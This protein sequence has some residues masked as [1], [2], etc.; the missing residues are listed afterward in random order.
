MSARS[1]NIF[2]DLE[3][4][5]SIGGIIIVF[6]LLRLL[7]L[8][9]IILMIQYISYKAKNNVYSMAA[10]GVLFVFPAYLYY[11]GIDTMK[12]ASP[13][14]CVSV[15]SLWLDN[16]NESFTFLQAF[17]VVIIAGAGILILHIKR[18]FRCA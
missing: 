10:N 15:V 13:V 1:L 7:S 16:I 18:N 11:V 14:K 2:R 12:Y 17:A 4:S 3:T 8:F 5:L 6:Y 9:M